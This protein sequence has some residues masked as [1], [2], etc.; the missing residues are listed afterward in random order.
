MI[1]YPAID[2]KDGQCVRLR[3]GRMEDA[4]AFNADPVAQ[5]QKF[6]EAGCDW[7]HIVDLNGA[8]AGK[9]VNAGAVQAILEEV[10]SHQLSVLSMGVTEQGDARS[11]GGAQRGLRPPSNIKIQLGG[12]IRSLET[13]SQWLELGI[14]RVILGT[15]AV[16]NPQLVKDACKH[17]PGKIAV[18]I[19]A[20][21][22]MAAVEGWAEASTITALELAQRFEDAGVAAIIHTDISRDGEMQGPNLEATVAL[23]EAITIPVIVSG[24]VSSLEDLRQIRQYSRLN[25]AI[26]GRALYEGMDIAAARRILEG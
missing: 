3:Q 10:V 1:L 24:G 18:G 4:T 26:I 25:G 17:Y 22:G 7:L 5:A 11:G 16:K 15:A 2:L 14:S 9:P 20:K 8:F 21:E 23:A 6:A 13:I 12:G 19:D